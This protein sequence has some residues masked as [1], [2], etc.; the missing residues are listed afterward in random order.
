ME[1]VIAFGSR[2]SDKHE[3]N[4]CVTRKE[5]FAVVH[6]LR[7]FKQ[8]L[9]GCRFR[10]KI[11]HAA[12]TWLKKTPDPIGQQTRWLEQME[13]FDFSIEHRPGTRHG[14]VDAMSRRPCPKKDCL[15]KEPDAPLFSGPAD[16]PSSNSAAGCDDVTTSNLQHCRSAKTQSR[17][18]QNGELRNSTSGSTLF[19]GPADHGRPQVQHR[20][21]MWWPA[22]PPNLEIISE[23]DVMNGETTEFQLNP[24]VTPYIPVSAMTTAAVQVEPSVPEDSVAPGPDGLSP[25]T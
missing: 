17:A 2:S 11:D 1:R 18:T 16:R 25:T 15:C 4:Y 22:V 6:F 5:L 21:R 8:Y 24:E 3:K 12:L 10:V 7:Y 14:N 19:I 13:E 20:R 9:L 23:E